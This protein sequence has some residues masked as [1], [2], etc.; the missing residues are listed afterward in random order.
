M[1]KNNDLVARNRDLELK[2]SNQMYQRNLENEKT[3]D[4]LNRSS[5]E[6]QK[7][8]INQNSTQYM[9]PGLSVEKSAHYSPLRPKKSLS[10]V[11]NESYYV[12]D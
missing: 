12:E 3:Q 2:L 7:Y 5:F 10:P 8:M 1:A 6:Q 11:R 9:E 4:I